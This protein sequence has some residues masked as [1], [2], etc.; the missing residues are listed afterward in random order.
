VTKLVDALPPDVIFRSV[1][2]RGTY[3][4]AA[5][6]AT[7]GIG[8]IAAGGTR[9]RT[10][11]I[12]PIHPMPAGITNTAS[13]TTT[14]TDPTTPN[15]VVTKTAVTAE[16]GVE[17]VSVRDASITPPFH[18]VPLGG[19]VQWDFF[20]PGVHEIVDAHGLGL[21]DSGPVT[22]V[23]YFR[24]TFD[25]SGE[26]RTTDVGY[27]DNAGKI[28][29]PLQVSPSNGRETTTFTLKWALS[30]LPPNLVEDVQIKRPSSS[31]WERYLRGTK[32]L[33]GAFHPDAGAG[34]YSFRD[35]I[36]NTAT[37]TWSRFGPPVSISVLSG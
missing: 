9:T 10:L 22:P 3:D 24:Y 4:A 17:Y 30:P 16:P 6:T 8:T 32:L 27:P 1:S 36:R 33:G 13:A 25:L 20:G 35:R 37:D 5:N 34:T 18:N 28:V 29:A 21:F 14:S 23:A 19:T 2:G 11:V 31:H 7:W 26:V 12:T 15:S